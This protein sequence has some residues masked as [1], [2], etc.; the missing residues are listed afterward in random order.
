MV[1]G[2]IS[3]EA[4]TTVYFFFGILVVIVGREEFEDVKVGDIV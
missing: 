2:L 4:V 3:S 1:E